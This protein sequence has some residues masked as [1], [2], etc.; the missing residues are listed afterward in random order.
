MVYWHILKNNSAI[1]EYF[2]NTQYTKCGLRKVWIVNY[3]IPHSYFIGASIA[4]YYHH[5]RRRR[6]RWFMSQFVLSPYSPRCPPPP[7]PRT[8]KG[9]AK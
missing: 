2:Q 4:H 6:H 3:I 1:E 5:R 9:R 8:L 7:N